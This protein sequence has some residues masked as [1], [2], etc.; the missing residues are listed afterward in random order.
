MVV[1]IICFLLQIFLFVKV[2]KQDSNLLIWALAGGVI[3]PPV[4][5]FVVLAILDGY[6]E[7]LFEG[8]GYLVFSYLH[9]L[10]ICVLLII[11]GVKIKNSKYRFIGVVTMLCLVIVFLFLINLLK[12]TNFK[13]GG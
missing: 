10:V 13:I 6:M 11:K 4:I 8:L 1:F 12:G 5:S 2:M 9:I 3:L 7:G